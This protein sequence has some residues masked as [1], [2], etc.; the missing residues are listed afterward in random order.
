M[1]RFK[2]YDF[3]QAVMIPVCLEDQLQPGTFE[4]AVHHLV[5]ERVP[6]DFFDGLYDNDAVGA[7]AYPPRMLVKVVL[8]GYSRGVYT[9]RKLERACREQVLFM[10]LAAG[11]AP[12]HSTFAGFV[13]KTSQLLP[14]LFAGVLLVCHE[15][16]LLEGTHFSLDGLK[17]P[18]NASKSYSGTFKDLA[19]K[20]DKLRAKAEALVG[21]HRAADAAEKKEK[22]KGEGGKDDDDDTPGGRAKR[23]AE[24]LG[25]QADKIDA[26]LSANE[27]RQ[28]ATGKEVQSNVTDNGSAKM[29]T[30]HGVVQG[31]NAQALADSKHQVI[32]WAAASGQGQDGGHVPAALGGAEENLRFA[33]LGGNPLEGAVFTADSNYHSEVNLRACEEHGLDA[34]IPD[35]NFRTRD[36][37]YATR[38]RHKAKERALREHYTN[39]DFTH[40]PGKDTYTC[41]EGRTL[42]LTARRSR[43]KGGVYRRYRA[44]EDCTGCPRYLRCFVRPGGKRPPKRRTLSFPVEGAG[45]SLCA[46]MRAKVD[47]ADARA[48]YALRQGIVEPPF[49][50]IRYC[51]GLSR[52]HYRGLRKV[53]AQWL[54]FCLVHNIGKLATFSRTYGPRP[55]AGVDKGLT[56]PPN[57]PVAPA[58]RLFD[59]S[60]PIASLFGQCLSFRATA[61]NA[62]A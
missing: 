2:P 37:L 25:K 52:F 22:R 16:G 43:S 51:K 38:E 57:T 54:L 26:F 61:G 55:P 20:R 50:N 21:Q 13:S 10:A 27:P 56:D 47:T 48:T 36:P 45:R 29:K 46:E 58:Y 62:A 34:Y 17:L 40:D 30:G 14:E 4:Y 53:N 33:G 6:E 60:K 19:G 18:G 35:N 23:A 11:Y 39:D 12:D 9:S 8:F 7:R 28:G 44:V 42:R 5:E 59:R 15:E 41:P 24:R 32:A 1:P 31:Y 3:D 49:A